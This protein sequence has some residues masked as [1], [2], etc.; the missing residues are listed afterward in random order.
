[1][2]ATL[3]VLVILLAGPLAAAVL[4]GLGFRGQPG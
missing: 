1:M 4:L 2:T 3:V